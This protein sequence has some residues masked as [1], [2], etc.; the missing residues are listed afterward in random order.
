MLVGTQAWLGGGL[1]LTLAGSGLLLALAGAALWRMR[2]A[3]AVAQVI[4]N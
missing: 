2:Q 1:V 4:E 3:H